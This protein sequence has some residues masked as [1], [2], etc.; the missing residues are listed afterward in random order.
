MLLTCFSN[1][2]YDKHGLLGNDYRLFEDTPAWE[3]AKAVK[4]EDV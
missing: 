4:K 3:L 1:C 2:R